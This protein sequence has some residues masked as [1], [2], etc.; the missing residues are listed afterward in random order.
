MFDEEAHLT[1]TVLPDLPLRQF[2]FTFPFAL[3]YRLAFDPD[4]CSA[5]RKVVMRTLSGFYRKRAQRKNL[6]AGET[7]SLAVQQRFGS[8]LNLNI[9]FHILCF[10][11]VF[12]APGE[13]PSVDFHWTGTPS[14]ADI[15]RL[16]KTCRQR[17]ERLLRKRGIDLD[18]GSQDDPAE[19]DPELAACLRDAVIDR[20]RQHVR[21]SSRPKTQRFPGKVLVAHDQGFSLHAD[22]AIP[23]HDSSRRSMLV[24]Y[25]LRPP[26]APSQLDRTRDGRV[27]FRLAHPFADGTSHVVWTKDAFLSRLAALVPRPRRHLLTYHGVLAP[28][29]SLRSRVVRVHGGGTTSRRSCDRHRRTPRRTHTA[30]HLLL[31]RAYGFMFRRCDR[32]GGSKRILAV[33]TQP[34]VIRDILVSLGLDPDPPSRAPP[35]IDPAIES[36]FE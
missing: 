1:E 23:A 12:S 4:L 9:H 20:Q 8:A 35:A 27:S 25:L 36:T 6:P 28:N 31:L 15:Q 11:G 2:V 5:V 29:H 7:G 10:D 3:R 22:T 14:V 17:L 33:I 30:H 26:L 13:E 32:C 19:Q 24:R 21:S 18:G 16:L 34:D